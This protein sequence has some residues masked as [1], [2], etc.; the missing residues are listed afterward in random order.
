LGKDVK[1]LV[2]ENDG[3]DYEVGYKRPPLHTRFKKNV[4]PPSRKGKVQDPLGHVL[5][6]ILQERRRVVIGEKA[7]W[8]SVAERL[9]QKAF[10][11]GEQGNS[12]M[13]CLLAKLLMP[14]PADDD[15][16]V[17]ILC[18]EEAP[19]FTGE[20]ERMIDRDGN[21]EVRVLGGV[22]RDPEAVE[23]A[24]RRVKQLKSP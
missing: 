21:V 7:Q 2:M 17:S 1:D 6:R 22:S 24:K 3:Q 19:A 20:L 8:L 18:D 16:D 5:W 13:N 14:K 11:L 23:F 9:V 12:T 15:V 10:E 4:A